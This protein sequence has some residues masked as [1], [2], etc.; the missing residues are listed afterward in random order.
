MSATKESP[1][2]GSVTDMWMDRHGKPK[3]AATGAFAAGTSGKPQGRGKRW[4]AYYVGSN[5]IRKYQ[6]FALKDEAE[7]WVKNRCA[8][9]NEGRWVNPSMGKNSFGEIAQRWLATQAPVQGTDGR[10]S[11][12]IQPKTYAD[13]EGLL[14]LL[15]IPKWGQVPIREIDYVGLTDWYSQLRVNGNGVSDQ[16]CCVSPRRRV[17]PHSRLEDRRVGNSGS[18]R[19]DPRAIDDRCRRGDVVR[20]VECVTAVPLQVVDRLK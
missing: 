14:R 18:R 13:Y 16:I 2:T 11:G 7:A 12:P 17:R 8:E 20:L 4:R 15:V 10:W 19:V 3:A 1:G 9:V 6:S 5:G